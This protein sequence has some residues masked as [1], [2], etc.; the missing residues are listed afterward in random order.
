VHVIVVDP[1]VGS[2][3]RIVAAQL[4]DWW[5]VAPD[6][7]LLTHLLHAYPARAA[8]ALTEPRYWR[9]TPSQTFHGRDIMAPVAAHLTLGGPLAALGP[10]LDPADLARLS[11]PAPEA[12]ARSVRGAVIHV[13]RFGNLI[14]NIPGTWLHGLE[15]RAGAIVRVDPPGV[16]VPLRRTY[17]DVPLGQPVA[18][19]GSTD[20]LEIAVR[21]GSASATLHSGIGATIEAEWGGAGRRQG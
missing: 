14:T 19:V 18:L 8:C 1:G 6:N 5:F 16:G 7:G 12:C 15:P 13:D 2:S 20:Y 17:A 10:A 4:G 3:R 11:L 21:N 9:P